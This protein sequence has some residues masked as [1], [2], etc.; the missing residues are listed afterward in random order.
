V[1]AG[2]SG[3]PTIDVPWR[4]SPNCTGRSDLVLLCTGYEYWLPFLNPELFTWKAG[5]PQLYLNVFNR[6]HDS[7]YVLG[8]IEFADAA[9]QRFDEMAQLVVMDIRARET[10]EHRAEL[11]ALKAEDHPDLRGGM[12][13]L[14]SLR[15]VNY[16]QSQ[17]YQSYLADLRDRF[18]WPDLHDRSYDDLRPATAALVTASPVSAAPR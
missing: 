4:R 10:G 18:S 15:H 2:T 3:P 14:D 7:L 17:A 6:T 5:H 9:Y 16:V 11:L 8:F 12:A 13:Y 1:C